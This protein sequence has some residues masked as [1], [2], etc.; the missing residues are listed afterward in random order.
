MP[1]VEAL[2]ETGE[3]VEQPVGPAPAA[4]P[5]ETEKVLNWL[6]GEGVRLVQLSGEWSCPVH[7][8]GAQR[9]E[10]EPLSARASEVSPFDEP[11]PS[12][13]LHQPAGAVPSGDAKSD[14]LTAAAG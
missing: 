13:P 8:A 6:E 10:L 1:Y 12:R 3:V 14:R 2:R 11:R 9:W 5:E 4:S 7:G